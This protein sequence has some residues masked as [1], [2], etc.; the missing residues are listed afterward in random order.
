LHRQVH[1]TIR[2]VTEDVGERLHFNTAIAAVMELVG[3]LGDAQ[4][5]AEPAV[6]RA[7][8]DAVLRLLA[9]FVPHV[10]A[11]LWEAVGH[12]AGIEAG[13][14]P[15]V[16]VAALIRDEVEL[17]VQVN[18]RLRGRILVPAAATAEAILAAALDDENVRTHLAGKPVRKHV[19]VPGR[20]LNLIA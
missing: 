15:A 1:E 8:V 6:L 13:G 10:A 16:D 2:R 12:T 3:A 18:G 14:W 20:M 7:G 17:P 11:E 9:P 5:S 4:A 19:L